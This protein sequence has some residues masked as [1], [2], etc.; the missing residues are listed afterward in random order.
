MPEPFVWEV[1]H[2]LVEAAA[3]MQNGPE[4]KDWNF[5]FVHQDI[6]PENGLFLQQE[7]W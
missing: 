6:K 5:E 1:F 3:A 7:V 2:Y 4:G